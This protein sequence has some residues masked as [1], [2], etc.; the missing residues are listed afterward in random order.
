MDLSRVIVGPIV[1]EKSERLKAGTHRTYT[2][3]IASEATKVDVKNA[4]KRHYELDVTSVRVIWV[5]AK[6]RAIG[7]GAEM[8]KRHRYK[9][10]LVTAAAKSKPLDLASFKSS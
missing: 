3:H 10:A 1:T 7:H 5:R 4:L 2:M 8:E 6:T 9:K